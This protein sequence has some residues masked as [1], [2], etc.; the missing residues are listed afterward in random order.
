VIEAA[1]PEQRA[2]LRTMAIRFLSGQTRNSAKG[3]LTPNDRKARHIAI[4]ILVRLESAERGEGMLYRLK[5]R[6][7]ISRHGRRPK[8]LPAIHSPRRTP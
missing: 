1:S 8:P 5:R 4:E 6:F 2:H 3:R 7:Q